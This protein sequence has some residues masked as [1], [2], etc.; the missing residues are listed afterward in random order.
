[1]SVYLNK[2]EIEELNKKFNS[3]YVE[4]GNR[5]LIYLK[6]NK[7]EVTNFIKF[8]KRNNNDYKIICF[9]DEF[10]HDKLNNEWS[11]VTPDLSN[12]GKPITRK[13]FEVR[14][15]KFTKQ[16]EEMPIII[17]KQAEKLKEIRL[18]DDFV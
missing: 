15:Q 14:L 13:E 1:M 7:N 16:L 11:L 17:K 5:L 8:K 2:N 6:N 12:Y 3:S 9:Y 4:Y 10:S 18:N